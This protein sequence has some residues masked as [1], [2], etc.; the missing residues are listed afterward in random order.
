MPQFNL[1]SS[2]TR[3]GR[4]ERPSYDP[5]CRLVS[6]FTACGNG[7]QTLDLAL[8]LGRKAASLGETVLI[9]DAVDGAL[10]NR[11]GVIYSRTLM[12]VAEGTASPQDALLSL[13]HI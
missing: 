5:A 11:A 13:I 8:S 7:E 1:T 2:V 12:D 6:L 3:D 9:L 4:G 10:M